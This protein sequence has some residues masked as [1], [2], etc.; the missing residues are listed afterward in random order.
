MTLLNGNFHT[1]ADLVPERIY[2]EEIGV[3][4]LPTH[5]KH[6]QGLARAAS[7]WLDAYIS[8]SRIW[9]PRAHD[10]FHESVGL[11]LLSTVAAHRVATDFGKRRYT[12][13]YIA[14]AG[15]TSVFAK[16]TTAEIAQSLLKAGGLSFLLAPDDA[17][18]QAFVRSMT[19]GVPQ[20]WENLTREQQE[21][22]K[23]KLAFAAQRGWYFDEF[24]QKISA[25]MREGGFMADF[26]GLLRKFDDTPDV[27]EYETIS[28][29][30]DTVRLPYLA[31]L[32]NLTPADL[33]PYAKK[34][35]ALW[36]DGFW[37]RFA[38]LAPPAAAQRKNH[39]FPRQNRVAPMTL[40]NPLVEWHRRLGLPTVAINERPAG[41]D[42]VVASPNPSVLPMSNEVY[43]LYYAYN[44]ALIDIVTQSQFTDLD[45]NYARL[46]EKALRVSMLLASLGGAPS[47][48]PTHWHRAQQVAE[49]WRRNLH[50]LYDQVV[51]DVETSKIIALEDKIM[52]VIAEHGPRTIREIVQGVRG[53]DTTQARLIVKSMV[54]TGFLA[55]MKDGRSERYR[56]EIESEKDADEH[57]V[58]IRSVDA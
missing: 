3:P 53:L 6:D 14:L 35:S 52:S 30:S 39:R 48:E 19:H 1:P 36:N 5:V 4:D 33:Q 13:L 18:P 51:G 10:D 58:P 57:A 27:Y 55:L 25:M 54:E 56:L 43:D 29:G 20:G 22:R 37:A 47:I 26:R 31:L 24:G 23:V 41:Y 45:G 15:R 17:T 40:V 28:R 32:A 49:V 12:S 9:S 8:Y 38:F 2:R 34:G 7:P 21:E 46:P 16:S 50:N 42:A 44:D 11:W